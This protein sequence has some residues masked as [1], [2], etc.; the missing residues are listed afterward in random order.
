M[1]SLMSG[2]FPIL[3]PLLV[4]LLVLVLMLPGGAAAEMMGRVTAV[5]DGDTLTVVVDGQGPLTVRLA[6][7]DAPE[8]YQDFGRQAHNHLSAL[9]SGQEVRLEVQGK[10]PDGST[11]TRLWIAEPA[12]QAPNCPKTLDVG[13]AQISSGLAWHDRPQQQAQNPEDRKRYARA[14]FMAKVRRFGLWSAQNPVPP[15]VWRR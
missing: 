1:S 13:L 4:P 15:W 12:C 14:E 11:V 10:A 3:V 7:I 5:A 6:G 2:L 9:V 8:R